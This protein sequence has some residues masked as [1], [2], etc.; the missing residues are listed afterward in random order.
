MHIV[1]T[2]S[3]IEGGRTAHRMEAKTMTLSNPRDLMNI[4][5]DEFGASPAATIIA[6]MAVW[7]A[8]PVVLHQHE[9]DGGITLLDGWREVV[10]AR[11]ALLK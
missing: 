10:S 5:R 6:D 7:N 4:I 1:C 3:Y 2:N 9:F 8:R 11:L